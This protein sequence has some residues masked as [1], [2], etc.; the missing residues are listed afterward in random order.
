M[1][2]SSVLI[3]VRIFPIKRTKN[4]QATYSSLFSN[5]ASGHGIS[6]RCTRIS[7]FARWRRIPPD[8]GKHANIVQPCRNIIIS[9]DARTYAH[10]YACTHA[11][12]S[13]FSRSQRVLRSQTDNASPSGLPASPVWLTAYRD[14]LPASGT[15][16]AYT[17]STRGSPV[18]YSGTVVVTSYA[19]HVRNTHLGIRA[20]IK[21][22]GDA[23]S[24]DLNSYSRPW[25]VPPRIIGKRVT[26]TQ[27]TLMR[28]FADFFAPVYKTSLSFIKKKKICFVLIGEVLKLGKI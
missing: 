2:L 28:D 11:R 14:I 18:E 22:H 9:V 24:F 20:Q 17:E 7:V 26:S 10:T 23:G 15:R 19:S 25:Y 16:S 21:T 8:D 12:T 4:N 1:Y 5:V 13:Q 3:Y 27:L 6:R